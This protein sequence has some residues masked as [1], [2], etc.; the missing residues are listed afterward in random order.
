MGFR[1]AFGGSKASY[2]CETVVRYHEGQKP[3]SITLHNVGMTNMIKSEL[4]KDKGVL[5]VSPV[6]PLA[7]SD[8]ERLAQE[9]DSYEGSFAKLSKDVSGHQRGAGQGGCRSVS[10]ISPSIVAKG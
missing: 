9:V 5:I 8:F 2:P 7:A 4:L 1:R 3:V 6:G 10:A